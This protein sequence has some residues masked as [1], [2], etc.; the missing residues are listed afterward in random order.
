MVLLVGPMLSTAS[1]EETSA[2]REILGHYEAIRITLLSD[3]MNDVAEHATAI[4]NRVDELAERFDAKDAGVPAEKGAECKELLPE[5]SSTASLLAE[6][7][8]IEEAREALFALSKPM[9]R[10]RKLAD[11][12]GS[13]VVFCSMAKKHGSSHMARSATPTWVRRCP[14]VERSLRT[15]EV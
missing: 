4:A 7:D 12:E 9:G 11:V 1:A 14:T 5:V 10:Y 15:S 13:M 2:Y 8:D 3:A 6:A